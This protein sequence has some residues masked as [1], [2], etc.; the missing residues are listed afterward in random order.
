MQVINK[1]ITYPFR[2][3][4]RKC[5]N[6]IRWM[7]T[8]WKDEDWDDSYITTILIKKLEHQRDFFLS[9]RTHILDAKKVAAE[10]QIA[11][12]GL[13]NTTDSWAYEQQANDAL[14][15]KWGESKMRTEPSKTHSGYY[16]LHI[17]VPGVKTPEDDVQYNKEFK[18]ALIAARKQYTKDKR[19]AYVYIA[20][21][22]DRWWD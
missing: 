19:A 8:I 17:D 3:F 11:I 12:D 1:H 16:E 7:P 21:N 18:E 9:D 13:R 22:I 5:H 14:D 2:R 6:V 4:F 20:S 10:I 15:R